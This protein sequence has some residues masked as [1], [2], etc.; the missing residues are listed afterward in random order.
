MVVVRAAAAAV[1]V[2]RR[3][4]S[5]RAGLSIVLLSPTIRGPIKPVPGMAPF[6]AP[7]SP[8]WELAPDLALT[9]PCAAVWGGRG[10]V[11]MARGGRWRSA[12][13]GV[14]KIS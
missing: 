10:A 2:D 13:A 11:A 12:A 9:T 1:Y 4:S 5:V 3:N 14:K 8:S 6:H 7:G